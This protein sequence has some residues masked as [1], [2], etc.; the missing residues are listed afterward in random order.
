ML[1]IYLI[2]KRKKFKLHENARNC[3]IYGERILQ[4]FTKKI[5]RKVRDHCNYTGKYK[6]IAH[7]I[8]I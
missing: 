8:G 4:K 6:S 5:Y 1:Q 7:S 3:Y 2:L